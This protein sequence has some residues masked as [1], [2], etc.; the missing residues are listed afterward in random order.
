MLLALGHLLKTTTVSDV[1][2]RVCGSGDDDKRCD[3][4]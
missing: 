2:L 4:L 1:R 3:L